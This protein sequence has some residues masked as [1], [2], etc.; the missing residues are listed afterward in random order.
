LP[1]N[2]ASA[3]LNKSFKIR[4]FHAEGSECILALPACPMLLGA[5]RLRRCGAGGT[6]WQWFYSLAFQ[7]RSDLKVALRGQ[8][9]DAPEGAADRLC[10]LTLSAGSLP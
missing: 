5:R 6:L 9:Q 3:S 10:E 8:C 2:P 4:G 7:P 1:P